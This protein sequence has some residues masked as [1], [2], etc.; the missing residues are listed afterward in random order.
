MLLSKRI[1]CIIYR[2]MPLC[3]EMK[4]Y[5][6]TSTYMYENPQRTMQSYY[7]ITASEIYLNQSQSK[8]VKRKYKLASRANRALFAHFLNFATGSIF[9]NCLLVQQPQTPLNNI[10][11]VGYTVILT[12]TELHIKNRCNHVE[13]I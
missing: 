7:I 8:I 13:N 5:V 3:F 10:C 11:D 2:Y 12:V 4:T 6:Q 9:K 1:T